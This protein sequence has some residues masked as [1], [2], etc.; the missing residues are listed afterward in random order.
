ML[1]RCE[2]VMLV[3]AALFVLAAGVYTIPD[4]V[5]GAELTVLTG[6]EAEPEDEQIIPAGPVDINSADVHELDQLP[7]IGEVLA[8]RIIEY[9]TE[10]GPFTS[11]EEL[12]N[13]SGIG[14]KT[15]ESLRGL[16]S[17]GE[18]SE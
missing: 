3:L 5:G 18:E 12:C 10:H 1:R 14:E 17:F 8:G 2:I 4:E 16:V 9:R 7:G 13:V 6:R 11:L 15:C